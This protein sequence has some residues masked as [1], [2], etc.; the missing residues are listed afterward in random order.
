MAE[1]RDF[2][3]DPAPGSGVFRV[4]TL[5]GQELG[6]VRASSVDEARRKAAWEIP[7]TDDTPFVVTEIPVGEV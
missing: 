6:R 2:G 4:T 5:K 3:R 7:A 1:V